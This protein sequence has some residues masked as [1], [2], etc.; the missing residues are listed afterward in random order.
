LYGT[1]FTIIGMWWS[2][3]TAIRYVLSKQQ[4]QYKNN[5]LNGYKTSIAMPC[6]FLPKSINRNIPVESVFK[7]FMA[8]FGLFIGELSFM[9][10]PKND[11][12]MYK[13]DY[14]H[15]SMYSLFIFTFTIEILMFYKFDLPDRLEHA[16]F[17]LSF[18]LNDLLIFNH[19]HG[20]EPVD[21]KLHFLLACSN[22]MMVVF[23]ILEFYNP[24]QILFTYGRVLFFTLQG[25]WLNQIAYIMFPPEG[26]EKWDMKSHDSIMRAIN[27]F[28]IFVIVLCFCLIIQVMVIKFIYNM[29]ERFRNVCQELVRLDHLEE[30][31]TTDRKNRLYNSSAEEKLLEYNQ[32][33][34]GSSDEIIMN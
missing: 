8:L 16:V 27:R 28:C 33:N 10:L 3:I 1:F 22:F 13:V 34:D 31:K 30:M 7:L 9:L 29:S 18:S 17:I 23:A 24:K 14:Q 2:L 15:V 25:V 26:Y 19:L 32:L 11:N 4:S 5:S 20:R 21:V 6:I 12:F